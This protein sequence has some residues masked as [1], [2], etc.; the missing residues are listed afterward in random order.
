MTNDKSV[1][2]MAT[3]G[4]LTGDGDTSY[5]TVWLSQEMVVS[6]NATPSVVEVRLQSVK[7]PVQGLTAPKKQSQA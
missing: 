5:K 7:W 1:T 6:L 3:S 4:A 2:G